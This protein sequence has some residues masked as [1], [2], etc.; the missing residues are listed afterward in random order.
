MIEPKRPL[1][2]H[3]GLFLQPQHFQHLDLQIRANA[4][5]LYS[6]MTP[7]FWGINQMRIQEASL[8]NGSFEIERVEAVFPDGTWV[9]FPGNC[10]LQARGLESAREYEWNKPL[11]VYL[12]LRK[13]NPADRNVAETDGVESFKEIPTRFLCPPEPESIRD[14]HGAGP[15]GDVRFLQYVLRIFLET[16][17]E[18]LADYWLIPVADLES[19][20]IQTVM[21]RRFVPPVFSLDGSDELVRLMQSIR[22]RISSRRRALEP[23]KLPG[24]GQMPEVEGS[25]LRSLLALITLNR[26][27]PLLHQIGGTTAVHP[28]TVYGILRQMVGEL[29]AFTDRIDALGRTIDGR[30]LVPDYDHQNLGGCFRDME[31]LIGE[32]LEILVAGRE[33]I[34]H[35]IREDDRFLGEIPPEAFGERNNFCLVVKTAEPPGRVIETLLH[36]GK[37]GSRE[38]MP[39]LLARALPGVPL[40]HRPAPPPGLPSKPDSVYFM[41]DRN[42]PQWQELRETG[43]FCLFWLDA[44]DDAGVDLIVFRA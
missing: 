22:E 6:R 19:S 10:V 36:A 17:I 29:S 31:T 12:G 3:Q 24:N 8:R 21:S 25:Y 37:A 9:A 42:H 13:W 20:G 39:V 41:L 7:F 40:T 5:P 23:Y 16:E 15:P 14:L 18:G 1:Y 43:S 44:P 35:L 34:I 32:L 4:A 2:W 11:R 27:I 33:N 28:W 38:S 30:P 26:Y